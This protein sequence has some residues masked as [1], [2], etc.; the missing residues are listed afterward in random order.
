[1]EKKGGIVLVL[2][3]IVSLPLLKFFG[4]IFDSFAERSVADCRL[5]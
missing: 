1:M 2:V 4:L 3:V 5:T